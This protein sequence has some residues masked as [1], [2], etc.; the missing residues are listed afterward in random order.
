MTFTGV[1]K[2]F[3]IPWAAHWSTWSAMGLDGVMG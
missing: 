1:P 2:M 3:F